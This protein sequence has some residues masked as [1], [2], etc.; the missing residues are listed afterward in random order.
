MAGKVVNVT[1][2]HTNTDTIAC[3]Q[4]ITI[5]LQNGDET[6]DRYVLTTR[7]PQK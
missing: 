4:P 1:R 3:P 7:T 2:V 5:K 6:N